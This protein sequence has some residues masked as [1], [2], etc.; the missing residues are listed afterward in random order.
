VGHTQ[1]PCELALLCRTGS[2]AYGTQRPDSDDD[3]RGVF[4]APRR[5]LFRLKQP[6]YTFDRQDPDVTLHELAVFAR[7]AAACNP[8]ILEVLWIDPLHASSLGRELVANRHLFLSLRAH[9]TY[10][11][12]ARQQLERARKGTGGSRG[13]AHYRREKFLLHTI[14]LMEAGIHLLRTGEV[15]VRVP[16]PD[17]LW[18]RARQP[19]HTIVG[20]FVGLDAQLADAVAHSPLP[21]QPDWAAIDTLLIRLREQGS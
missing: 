17:A 15:Q 3:Y 12:Y 4:I 10:G 1:S 13:Q 21:S 18:A 11:G 16:D 9:D 6:S 5:D 14:R 20:Q 8:T 2:H 19:L 7:L